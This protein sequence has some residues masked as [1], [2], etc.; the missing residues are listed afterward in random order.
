[1][2]RRSFD[3]MAEWDSIPSVPT[4]GIAFPFD[5]LGTIIRDRCD[6][7]D[8]SNEENAFAQNLEAV[9]KNLAKAAFVFHAECALMVE[10]T[11]RIRSRGIKFCNFIGVSKLSCP[12]CAKFIEAWREFFKMD[13]K[14]S[15]CHYKMY[16]WSGLPKDAKPHDESLLRCLEAV[17]D[18]LKVCMP[19][20]C[21]RRYKASRKTSSALSDSSADDDPHAMPPRYETGDEELE[22][23]ERAGQEPF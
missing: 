17:L 11:R 1:M 9:K 10:A 8:L 18:Y 12:C 2:R 4:A 5:T 19:E 3:E 7:H 20:L 14:T 22:A 13:W 15:G 6:L 23:A 16:R 21:E